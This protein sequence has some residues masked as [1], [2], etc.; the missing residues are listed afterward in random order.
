MAKIYISDELLALFL[1]GKTTV[2]ESAAILAAAKDN[3]DIRYTIETALEDGMFWNTGV[4]ENPA[5]SV[6]KLY[7][8]RSQEHPILRLAASSET[9]DCVVKCE[10][11][12]LEAFDKEAQ[13]EKLLNDARQHDWLRKDGTPLYNIGRLLEMAQLSVA[14]RLDGTLEM[15]RRDLEGGCSVIV[16]LNAERLKTA[17]PGTEAVANHAVVVLCVNASEGL[18]EIF[19]PQST[20]ECDIYPFNEFLRAWE[21]SENFW[22]SIVE[23][24]VR[25]YV[26]HPEDVEHIKLD[27]DIMPIADML[28]ENAHEIWAVGRQKEA[29]GDSVKLDKDPYM[30]PFG[31]LS[32][33]DRV[34]DYTTALNTIKLLYKL[35]FKITWEQRQLVQYVPNTRKAGEPYVP[36]PIFADDVVL[37]EDVV[38]LTE[39]I[40]ENVHE[41]W[42]KDRIEKGWV[43]A[44]VTDK[45]KREHADLVPYCELLDSEKEY[46]RKMAMN[47][48]KVLYKLGYR[49]EKV[50]N[51]K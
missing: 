34:S 5:K 6:C 4:S 46:D 30:K 50:T 26:P 39:Y 3:L 28:A 35:G 14:R 32:E 21:C 11:Y 8:M 37:P 24:G 9:N 1:E 7:E 44:P 23:R 22:V 25:P 43:Y 40:A 15:L 18:V 2:E 27:E 29:K 47:T 31:E 17:S 16:A 42:S 51:F 48:L 10:Q 38:Q 41:D 19:D 45:D 12:V 36:K 49:I 33:E 13:Y 20:S